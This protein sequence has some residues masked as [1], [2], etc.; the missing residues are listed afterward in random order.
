[1]GR[2]LS[3]DPAFKKYPNLS[4]FSY[5][6][7][8]PISLTDKTG[9][10]ITNT[11]TPGTKEYIQIEFS[12]NVLKHV[13]PDKYK[14]MQ[15]STVDFR[16]DYKNL[17]P[18]GVKT[19]TTSTFSSTTTTTIKQG[20]LTE[21]NFQYTDGLQVRDKTTDANGNLTGGTIYRP[22]TLEEQEKMRNEDACTT[23]DLLQNGNK[24][25]MTMD[26]AAGYIDLPAQVHV[27]LDVT[28]KEFGS[29]DK[30]RA[31]TLGHELFGHA[32]FDLTHKAEAWLWDQ[33]GDPNTKDGPGHDPNNPTGMAAKAAENQVDQ[34]YKAATHA[35]KT[36]QKAAQPVKPKSDK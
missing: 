8:N 12:L 10:V 4:W 2:F 22:R 19:T 20:G 17:N 5:V 18:D 23:E 29:S 35:I 14:T 26:E 36:E 33:I 16:I 1:L 11:E 9:N 21:C 28:L 24:A 31:T 3:I 13:D 30:E 25:P 6:A 27:H 15:E 34:G 7:D 32:Y